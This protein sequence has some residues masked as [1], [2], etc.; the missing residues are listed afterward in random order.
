MASKRT[1][2]LNLTDGE[3]AALEELCEKK[4]L[5]KLPC[6]GKP[7]GSTSWLMRLSEATSFSLRMTPRQRQRSWS[8]EWCRYPDWAS[9][10][11]RG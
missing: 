9:T 8:C 2:T 1:M 10:S 6:S 4:D 3:M 7:L 11:R 5:S